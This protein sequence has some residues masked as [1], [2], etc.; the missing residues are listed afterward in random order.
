M[1]QNGVF[2]A[3][4]LSPVLV[5]WYS[6]SQISGSPAGQSIGAC[7][8]IGARVAGFGFNDNVN[9]YKKMSFKYTN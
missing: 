3:I 6:V 1:T 8:L 9:N 4:H 5:L 7:S 2:A